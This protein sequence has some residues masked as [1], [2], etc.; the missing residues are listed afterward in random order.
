MVNEVAKKLRKQLAESE[1]KV[2]REKKYREEAREQLIRANAKLERYE[3][4]EY[5]T[6][7]AIERRMDNMQDQVTWL[8]ELVRD[9]ALNPAT[10]KMLGE[11]ERL[12]EKD[13]AKQHRHEDHMRNRAMARQAEMLAKADKN[14]SANMK[15]QGASPSRIGGAMLP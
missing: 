12:I 6:F 15:T 5:K 2:E 3:N 11:N 8:R 13:R 14:P 4:L 9:L 1:E 7:E 10:I